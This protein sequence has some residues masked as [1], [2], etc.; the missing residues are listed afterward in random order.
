VTTKLGAVLDKVTLIANQIIE[1]TFPD[2]C[3]IS[4]PATTIGDYGTGAPSY[5]TV[6]GMT[7]IGCAWEAVSETSAQEYIRA[8]QVNE[9]CNYK[10]T[11]AS[12]INGTVINL[13]PKDRVVVASRG[14]EPQRTFEVKGIIRNAGL[15]LT[16]LCTLEE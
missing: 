9:V 10:I 15:P 7:G 3:S 12:A 16:V 6:T 11:M 1:I 5:S 13:K 4:R 14:I 8:G 2:Q